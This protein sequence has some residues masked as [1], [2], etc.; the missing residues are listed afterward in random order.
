[1]VVRD[2]SLWVAACTGLKPKLRRS[3]AAGEIRCLM[4]LDKEEIAKKDMDTKSS[5]E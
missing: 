2:N 1:M 5:N 3:T 4:I